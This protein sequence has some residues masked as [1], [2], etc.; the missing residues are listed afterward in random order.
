MTAFAT[1]ILLLKLAPISAL[2]VAAGQMTFS[3]TSA[4]A[5]KQSLLVHSVG[6]LIV[7]LLIS[8]LAIYKPA[9]VTPLA[10]RGEPSSLPRWVRVSLIAVGVL[11]LVLALLVMHGGHGPAM[12]SLHA[13]S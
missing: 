3:P 2:A 4:I 13:P 11:T 1:A 8:M 9:G 5:L 6:G 7:L 12:H 10:T